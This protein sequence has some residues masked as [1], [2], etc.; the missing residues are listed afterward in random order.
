MRNI[1]LSLHL[2]LVVS[3]VGCSDDHQGEPMSLEQRW[4]SLYQK[5]GCLTGGQHWGPGTTEFSVFREKEWRSFFSLPSSSTVLFLMDRLSSTQKTIVHVCPFDMATEGELALYASEH[6][7]KSNWFGCDSR[8]IV[9]RKW[10]ARRKGVV[11]PLTRLILEDVDARNELKEYF[12]LQ[13]E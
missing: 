9:L 3:L 7:L 8:F 12:L 6:I 10:A 4:I 1:L 2:L 5:E 11:N 13:L